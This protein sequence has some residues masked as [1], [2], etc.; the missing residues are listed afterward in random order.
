[1]ARP[2]VEDPHQD[3]DQDRKDESEFGERLPTLVLHGR[4]APVRIVNVD[5]ADNGRLLPTT[6]ATNGVNTL[7]VQEMDTVAS[8]PRFFVVTFE[9]TVVSVNTGWG[10]PAVVHVGPSDPKPSLFTWVA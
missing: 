7:N 4:Y 3:Q 6:A 8:S 2:E 1:M 9:S 10:T 5:D